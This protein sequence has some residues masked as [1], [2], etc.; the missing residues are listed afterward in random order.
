MGQ[1]VNEAAV[2]DAERVEDNLRDHLERAEILAEELANSPLQHLIA[3]SLL[4]LN[5]LD[6]HTRLQALILREKSRGL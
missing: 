4:E 3:M 2:E 5:E 6:G 1:R